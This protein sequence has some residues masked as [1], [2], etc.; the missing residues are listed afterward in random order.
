LIPITKLGA[1]WSQVDR[2]HTVDVIDRHRDVIAVLYKARHADGDVRELES[3]TA[4][5]VTTSPRILDALRS[6]VL[7]LESPC[8]ARWDELDGPLLD[9]NQVLG[10]V[11][12]DDWWQRHERLPESQEGREGGA[13]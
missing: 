10:D 8:A 13:S 3:I 2:P 9:A 12:G 5:L 1:P 7:A 6:L 11:L 4:A